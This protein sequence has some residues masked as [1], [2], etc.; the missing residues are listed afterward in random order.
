MAY[1]NY[2]TSVD[3]DGLVVRDALP[4][5]LDRAAAVIEAAYTEYARYLPKQAWE[6]Y[7]RDIVDVRRRLPIS[8]LIVAARQEDILGAVTFYP[9]GSLS[10][11]EGWPRG[12]AGIRLLAAHPRYRGQGVGKVL[13]LECLRRCRERRIRTV[14][15]HTTEVMAVARSMYERMGFVR[16]PEHDFTPAPDVVVMAYRLEL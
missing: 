16:V 6:A 4:E 10:E 9:D 8:E 7:L 14:G 5:E 1:S 12:W 11:G 3:G 13:M 15:L 2:T